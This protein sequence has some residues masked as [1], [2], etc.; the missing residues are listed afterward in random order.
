MR[1]IKIKKCEN[2]NKVRQKNSKGTI[3]EN[4]SI[5]SCKHLQGLSQLKLINKTL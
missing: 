4:D 5:G 2:D 1:Y 3:Q